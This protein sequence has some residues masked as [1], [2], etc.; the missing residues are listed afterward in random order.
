MSTCEAYGRVLDRFFRSRGDHR[1]G[2]APPRAGA[3]ACAPARLVYSERPAREIAVN[4][5]ALPLCAIAAVASLSGSGRVREC[6][7]RRHVAN[8]ALHEPARAKARQRLIA[9]SRQPASIEPRHRVK[10]SMRRAGTRLSSRCRASTRSRP[11]PGP[12]SPRASSPLWMSA[13]TASMGRDRQGSRHVGRL[14]DRDEP[15]SACGGDDAAGA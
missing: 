4:G 11:A 9:E 10:R 2:A 13:A 1:V 3:S 15:A 14:R 6:G 8:A 7:V 5:H 12:I